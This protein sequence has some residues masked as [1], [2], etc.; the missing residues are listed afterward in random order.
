MTDPGRP[1]LYHPDYCELAHNYCLLGA[2]NEDLGGFFGVTPRTIDNWIAG[3]PEFATAVREGKA[4]ADARVA[5]S[6]FQRALGHEQKV[7][8]TVWHFGKERPV[9]DTLYYPPD[10][11]ACIFWLRNRQ[12]R[13]WNRGSKVVEDD[14]DVWAAFDA[15]G[16]RAGPPDPEAGS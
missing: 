2:T 3:H 8:R 11:R 12:P 4:V 15:A 10:I 9:S 14:S 1:T 16:E 5:R 7:E 6:L 13:L